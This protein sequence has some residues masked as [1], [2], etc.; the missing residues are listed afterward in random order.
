MLELLWFLLPV[1]AASGWYAARRHMAEV[2]KPKSALSANYYQGVNFLL[3]EQ[4]DKAI[5]VFTGMFE[6]N[7][8]T[9][10]IHMVLGNLFRRRGEVD[11]AIRIHQNLIARTTLTGAQRTQAMLEL[12]QDYMHVG[13]FDRAENLFR[14]IVEVQT[15]SE[16]ALRH[17][18]AIYQQ[19]KEW[20]NAIGVALQLH[21][22]CA[23]NT[24]P[25]VAHF[26]C[27]LAELQ[28][29]RNDLDAAQAL[30][31]RARTSD[32]R[33]VRAILG[34]GD[35][36]RQ[37]REHEAAIR[38]Y[39][40]VEQH[41]DS[42]LPEVMEPLRICFFALG[43]PAQ[44]EEYL[45][46]LSRRYSGIAPLLLL[47]DLLRETQGVT[48]AGRFLADY[49]EHYPSVRGLEHWLS[50]Q[51][52][53]LEDGTS[54]TALQQAQTVL[55]RLLAQQSRYR[56]KQCGYTLNTLHWQCPGCKEW[57]SIRPLPDLLCEAR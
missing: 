24:A 36:M 10:E 37:L 12:G 20:Q 56:C 45:H 25:V 4:P 52:T 9:V 44:M 46:A 16:P 14:E 26:Y 29:A 22:E 1:A 18:L 39:Q 50:L 8:E 7:S 17:L 54:Q 19:E 53:V 33:C 49:L 27:E 51:R 43:Q 5:E 42:Y 38:L 41:D 55:A 34:L 30:Y 47:T 35:L 48:V 40:S 3:N 6:V 31:N 23:V 28:L 32:A 2:G 21:K 15:H 11:R 13:L 57:G